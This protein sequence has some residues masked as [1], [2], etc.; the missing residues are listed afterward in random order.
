[1]VAG[2][3]IRWGTTAAAVVTA[4]AL[5][6]LAGRGRSPSDAV[7]ALLAAVFLFQPRHL[8][9]IEQAWTEPYALALLAGAFAARAA[10]R[11]AVA[12]LLAGLFLSIKQHL[13]LALP[14]LLLLRPTRRETV[15]AAAGV[16]LP[17]LPFLVWDA[18]ALLEDLLHEG[19][20]LLAGRPDAL[21]LSAPVL[22]HTGAPIPPV[23]AVG[24]ALLTALAVGRRVGREANDAAVARIAAATFA[25]LFLLAPKS[26]CNYWHLVAGFAALSLAGPS[27]PAP[28]TRHGP[29]EIRA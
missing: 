3:D 2:A 29:D 11:P 14:A 22:R 7:P 4:L 21:S 13:F 20:L 1:M 15:A 18:P 23:C 28:G 12:G 6:Y 25:V 16:A 8:F 26:F 24:T 27:E 19:P 9:V 10:G 5:R 17:L